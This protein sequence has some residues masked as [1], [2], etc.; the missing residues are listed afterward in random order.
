M[1]PSQR[2]PPVYDYGRRQDVI[3][4]LP[5]RAVLPLQIWSVLAGTHGW[6][7]LSLGGWASLCS[8]VVDKVP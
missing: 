3:S 4:N 8:L 5:E 1:L 7:I 6:N 2:C